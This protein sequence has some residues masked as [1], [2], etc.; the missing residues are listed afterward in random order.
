MSFE[1]FHGKVLFHTSY[2]QYFKENLKLFDSADFIALL[3]QHLSARLIA[4]V[5]EGCASQRRTARWIRWSVLAA[6]RS[7]VPHP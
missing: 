6:V 7:A 3:T 5:Y 2:N 1:S 4:K